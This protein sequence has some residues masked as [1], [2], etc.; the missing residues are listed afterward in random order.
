MENDFKNLN[1]LQVTAALH[2][3][4][5]ERGT[6]EMARFLVEQNCGSF[7]ASAGGQMVE[8]LKT[9]GGV[10]FLL[11]LKHRNPVSILYSAF[12][13][14]SIIKRNNIKLVHARSRA[15]AWA[16]YLAAKWTRTPFITTF[17]GTHKI[18]NGFKRF[19][20]SSM[21]RGKRVIA[22]SQFI[23]DH[24]IKNYGIKAAQIDI[25]HRGVDLSKF[26]AS[27]YAQSDI[28]ILKEEWGISG[29]FV[30]ALPGRL[31]RWKGQTYLL[32]ALKE[33]LDDDSWHAIF[34]G[35]AGKKKAY[36]E[37]LQSLAVS[38]G[39]EKRVTFTGGQA[40]IAP[41]YAMSDVIVSA[42][43]QPEA[44][45]RVAI[46]AGAMKKPV[47]ATAHGGSLETVKASE[48]GFLVKAGDVPTMAKIL[49]GFLKDNTLC[50][51]MGSKAYTWVKK[52]FTVKRMCEAEW[53][54][55]LKVLGEK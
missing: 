11:P 30:I 43:M 35:G 36:L 49:R 15:P 10:H 18:Q 25:A 12:K 28:A 14:V 13:L 46:E 21:V 27:K 1:V 34:V 6:V 52:S 50:E 9:E 23:K 4:G 3:G 47:V 55:Y 7:V 5:V 31:T 53:E 40:D 39:L 37:E 44:F 42:S 45:G 32:K 24:I 38:L 29:K 26:D 19:Y 16:A 17:H 51:K 33:L 20:N 48:T 41:F 2:E 8:E 54:A 22:I